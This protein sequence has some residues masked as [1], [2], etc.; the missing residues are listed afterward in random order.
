VYLVDPYALESDDTEGANYWGVK[1][2]PLAQLE[3][4]ARER[5]AKY[6]PQVTFVKLAS[7]AASSSPS[8]PAQ[9]D[10]VYIDGNHNYRAVTE[11][12]RA[13]WPK[14]RPGGVLGGHDFYNGYARL[15]DSVVKA[16]TEFAVFNR[17]ALQVEL[18]D[19]WILRA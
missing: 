10:F 1:A 9:V 15:H 7:V 14:I 13:W 18:P 3:I 11:D 8:T 5:L 2:P 19:W 6:P 16:V 12:I 17:L 4:E